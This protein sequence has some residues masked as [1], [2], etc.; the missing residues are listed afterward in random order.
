MSNPSPIG[1]L[2]PNNVS[3]TSHT[4]NVLNETELPIDSNYNELIHQYIHNFLHHKKSQF[5]QEN[6]HINP[7]S[8]KIFNLPMKQSASDEHVTT[9]KKSDMP[10]KYKIIKEFRFSLNDIKKELINKRLREARL[11]NS[12]KNRNLIGN[13]QPIHRSGY[14]YGRQPRTSASTRRSLYVNPKRFGDSPVSQRPRP[15]VQILRRSEHTRN[16]NYVPRRF[17]GQNIYNQRSK[18]L[19]GISPPNILFSHG[20]TPKRNHWPMQ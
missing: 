6:P 4:K 1:H 17:P 10:P 15:S 3:I 18:S 13:F 16:V 2:E 12:F 14:Q 7:N 8:I 9:V 5:A 19:R 11:E 20:M